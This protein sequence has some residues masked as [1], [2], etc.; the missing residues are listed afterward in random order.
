[1]SLAV[2]VILLVLGV[3]AAMALFPA[4]A[5]PADIVFAIL[6]GWIFY[7]GRVLFVA[8]IDAGGVVKAIVYLVAFSLGCHAF[9]GWLVTQIRPESRWKRRW[10]ASLVGTVMAMF[11]A[12]MATA[13]AAHQAF[14]LLS[15]KEHLMGGSNRIARRMQSASNLRN[16]GLGLVGHANSHDSTFPPGGTFDPQGRGLHG[17][18]TPILPYV[19]A[20]DL[21]DAIDRSVP[22]D[23][24][25]NAEFFKARVGVY[26]NPSY[27]D[28]GEGYAPSH[29]AGNVRLLGG[30]QP[31]SI[32][33][34]RF[35]TS[36]M[37]LAGEV[38]GRFRPWGSPTNWRDP[39]LGIN[40]S[41][42]GFGGP[43]RGGANILM[44]DGSV[45]FIQDGIDPKVWDKLTRPDREEGLSAD[46]Y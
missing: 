44:A 25:R 39:A 18:Q 22:W 35:G 10:T 11:V 12:G 15:G 27:P 13:G 30:N 33:S 46:D 5:L 40:K 8:H 42:D 3:G 24:P 7:L 19:D 4:T 28:D 37:V 21:Y 36:S 1:M 6:A 38:A 16:I 26:M 17:W 41:P 23:D 43:S 31:R 9:L 14:W 45:R 34:I 32:K 20:Q 29:Y 2:K